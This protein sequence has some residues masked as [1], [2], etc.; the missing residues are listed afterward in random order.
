MLYRILTEDKN[1][2]EIRKLTEQYLVDATIIQ[3][4][5][6]WQG[7]WE[8]CLIIETTFGKYIL[9]LAIAI[10]KLN[11]QDAVMIQEIECEDY[12]I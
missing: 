3:G 4:Q 1:I 2:V 7:N 8:N 11:K 5:G 10:K 12:L 6:L 9:E